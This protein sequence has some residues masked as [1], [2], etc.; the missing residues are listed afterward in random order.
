MII[1]VLGKAFRTAAIYSLIS[2]LRKDLPPR[3]QN[4]SVRNTSLLAVD[5]VEIVFAWKDR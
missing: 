5:H 1:W 4:G 2:G 3:R